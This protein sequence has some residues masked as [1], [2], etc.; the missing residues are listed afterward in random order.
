V[1]IGSNN[2]PYETSNVVVSGN[3]FKYCGGAISGNELQNDH[4]SIYIRGERVEIENNILIAADAQYDLNSVAGKTVCA[5]DIGSSRLKVRGNITLNYT[6]A[7]NQVSSQSD[8]YDCL[9]TEN[10]FLGNLR[11]GITLW[12]AATKVHKNVRIVGNIIEMPDA[13]AG[14]TQGGGITQTSDSVTSS[15]VYDLKITDNIIYRNATGDVVIGTSPNAGIAI[16]A[17]SGAQIARNTCRRL[18]GPGI[19]V[20]NK[21][22]GGFLDVTDLDIDDNQIIDCARNTAVSSPYG[23]YIKNTSTSVAY[24]RINIRRNKLIC[25]DSNTTA[26]GYRI[27]GTGYMRDVYLH[28]DNT[29]RNIANITLWK[30]TANTSLFQNVSILPQVHQG[31]VGVTPTYGVWVKGQ[32][33]VYYADPITTGFIGLVV[34]GNGGGSSAAWA[35]TTA[36]TRGQW[37]RTSTNK[38]LECTVGGTSS[39]AEPAPTTTGEVVTDGTVTW[40][41][42]TSSLATFKTWGVIS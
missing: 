31:L 8:S 23:L 19:L 25:T 42:R 6:N 12:S 2:D 10:I 34:T 26:R 30:S 22:S 11:S 17:V 37:I 35:A 24:E 4:S 32:D 21:T 39:G 28:G 13:F 27:E 1:L 14:V 40:V 9:W 33:L 16:T 41:Y 15:V 7:G 38:V 18:L 5:L 3:L 29:V 20:T 36:Y